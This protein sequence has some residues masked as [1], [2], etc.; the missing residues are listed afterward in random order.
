MASEQVNTNWIDLLRQI[1]CGLECLH[2][3]YKLI[4]NDI[5]GDNIVLSLSPEVLN[6]KPV[7]IDFGKACEVTKGKTYKLTESEKDKY[8]RVHTHIAPDLRDGLCVQSESSDVYSFGR[9]LNRA[10][11]SYLSEHTE[12]NDLSNKCMQYHHTSRP[13]LHS[14]LNILST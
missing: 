2:N 6:V 7:I 13:N 10:V 4:H 12:L 14:I 3:K 9:L 11:N 5:K 8:K 1:A